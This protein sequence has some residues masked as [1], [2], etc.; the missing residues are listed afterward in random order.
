MRLEFE[1]NDLVVQIE[2]ETV[3]ITSGKVVDEFDTRTPSELGRVLNQSAALKRWSKLLPGQQA[4]ILYRI[5]LDI[6]DRAQQ[7][8][9]WESVFAQFVRRFRLRP[10]GRPPI[11]IM[12]V[13]PVRARSSN[14]PFTLPLRMIEVNASGR[15]NIQLAASKVFHHRSLQKYAA[16]LRIASVNW[17][18]WNSLA[19]PEDWPTAEVLHFNSLPRFPRGQM[20]SGDAATPGT[21]GWLVEKLIAWQVRLLV[22][23]CK[24]GRELENLRQFASAILARGGP[25]VL[26]EAFQS[27]AKRRHFYDVFYEQLIHDFPLDA[28]W[29]LAFFSRPGR[30]FDASLFVGGGRAEQL[31]P[32]N[33]ALGLAQFGAKRNLERRNVTLTKTFVRRAPV[34][35]RQEIHTNLEKGLKKI[36]LDWKGYVFEFRERGALLP[37]SDRLTNLRTNL[38][39]PMAASEILLASVPGR[40]KSA[41]PK[42]PSPRYVNSSFWEEDNARELR[43]IDQ[44]D[45]QFAVDKLYQLGIQVGPKSLSVITVNET[46]LVEE[47]FKWKPEMKGVWIEIGVSGIDFD[48]VGD[49]VQRVWLPAPGVGPTDT[50]YFAV[51]P[52][53]SGVNRLRFSLY[54][55]QNV[56]QSF[57]IGAIA[58]P[59]IKKRRAAFT[60]A[61]EIPAKLSADVAYLPVLEFSLT[62]SIDSF[63]ARPSNAKRSVAIVANE[64]GG[65]SVVTVKNASSFGVNVDKLIP[66]QVASL[67]RELLEIS[68]LDQPKPR[69]PFTLLNEG[70][71]TGLESALRTLAERGAM[72]FVKLIDSNIWDDIRRELEQPDQ[73]IQVAQILRDKVI[74]WSF[75]YGRAL[76]PRPGDRDKTGKLTNIPVCLAPLPD[77]NGKLPVSKCGSSPACV[78]KQNQALKPENVV[79]PLEFWGFK[80]VVEIPP[81]Q[82]NTKTQSQTPA[83]SKPTA[84]ETTIKVKGNAR[85]VAGVNGTLGS[86]SG[87]FG[88]LAKLQTKFPI[89]A[90]KQQYTFTNLRTEL[91]K[92]PVHIAYFFCHA[93]G[94]PTTDSRIVLQEPKTNLPEFVLWYQF[95]QLGGKKKWNPPALVFMN[96]CQSVNFSPEALS[97]FLQSFVDDLGASGLIG[98]EI[99]VWDVFAAEVGGLFLESFLNGDPAGMS[100]LKARRVLLSKKNPL[101]LV[102]T[103][104][105]SADLHL[106]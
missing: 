99:A 4:H 95:S 51:I 1:R 94:G 20:L 65:E 72:L 42:R 40:H 16:A 97:P 17:K 9:S 50:V 19:L 52:R 44:K 93:E 68:N 84:I 12:R 3:S 2:E 49:P 81:K 63:A 57:R 11:V 37:L 29:Q 78:L 14:I 92:P 59:Q 23:Q 27:A 54:Y 102:Y 75:V 22:V 87:H 56:I 25:A 80:H 38:A 8:Q 24:P 33:V 61:L 21:L 13:S 66:H 32:S 69:Y 79:C 34:R 45:G 55:E 30:D 106:E 76:E 39:G 7:A 35:R 60:E 105:A 90:F 31:R 85:V 47:V 83:T 73:T 18:S 53:K 100:L 74:P 101:G 58:G 67:H 96:A 28:M 71:Q 104:F 91:T 41:G 64:L 10:S 46:A 86:E 62:P 26:V 88:A 15:G 70:N 82:V 43:Q 36:N 6:R 5:T 77:A 103:L 89:D 98:T 48:V